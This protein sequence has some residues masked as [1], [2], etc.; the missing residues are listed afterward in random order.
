VTSG[1]TSIRRHVLTWLLGTMSLAA[2]LLA[3]VTYVFALQTMNEVFD[4]ELRQVALTALTHHQELADSR[5]GAGSAGGEQEPS[6]FVTQVWTREGIRTFVS[7]PESS[8]P[9]VREEGYQTVSTRE[10]PWRVFTAR[11]AG[12]MIQAAQP[13]AARQALAASIAFKMLIPGLIAAP[14]LAWLISFALRHG[15]RPLAET[16]RDVEMKSAKSLAPID[17]SS[18]PEELQPLVGSINALMARLSAALAA[19]REFVADAAHELRTPLAAL[20]LQAQLLETADGA[21]RAEAIADIRQGI[22]RATRLVNQLLDLSRL[23]PD[24]VQARVEPIDLV[25]LIRAVVA[26]F[27]L[28]AEARGIDLGADIVT[29]VKAL[30]PVMGDADE[31]RTLLVNLID[32]ALIY[33]PAGGRVDVSADSSPAATTLSVRDSGPG[34]AQEERGRVFDRF[35][36]ASSA[37]GPGGVIQGTGLGLAI[38]KAIAERQHASVDL[39]EGLPNASGGHGLEVRV[40]FRRENHPQNSPAA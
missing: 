24:A 2:V 27:S 39:G 32:N 25:T 11:S 26:D 1:I 22:D 18:R 28:K 38:V 20:Q 17:V 14:L 9:F 40:Q 29:D 10:G 15:L 6:A 3:L 13:I 31:L 4:N 21:D 12:N 34:I 19:Q 23:E 36:R 35:Y 8:I 5:A 33:T 7:V 16:S 30:E 37:Q